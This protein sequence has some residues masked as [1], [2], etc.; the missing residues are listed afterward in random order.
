MEQK[1]KN[2]KRER[3]TSRNAEENPKIETRNNATK[4][5]T[6][7]QTKNK[8]AHE[9]RQTGCSGEARPTSISQHQR[10]NCDDKRK[11]MMRKK[12]EKKKEEWLKKMMTEMEKRMRTKKVNS[13][14]RQE[15]DQERGEKT[16]EG[17]QR[18]ECDRRHTGEDRNAWQR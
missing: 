10:L 16:K 8:P 13:C 3:A 17:E 2:K 5:T 6:A 9:A 12:R 18:L 11:K 4:I 14:Q 1:G 15:E 7:R